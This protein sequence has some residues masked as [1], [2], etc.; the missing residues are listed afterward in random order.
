VAGRRLTRIALAAAL[1][2]GAAEVVISPAFAS[3]PAEDVRPH[4][5]VLS[6]RAEV[7]S[8]AGFSFRT[9]ATLQMGDVVQVVE[10]GKRGGFTRVRLDSGTTGWILTEQVELFGADPTE[11]DIGRM[12]R[13]GRKLRETLLGPPNLATARIGGAL[14]AGALGREGLFL[15]RP[16]VFISPHVAVEGFVGPSVGRETSRGIFGL[17]ANVYLSPHI[18]FTPFLSVGGGA[19]FN[20]G[21][22]DA[23]TDARW[24]YLASPGGGLWIIFKRGVGL[25]FDFRNHVL[26]RADAAQSLQEYS[27]ALAFT[28]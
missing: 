8:G 9:I 24:S 3:P 6:E 4:A 18:P 26:F 19:V 28:F 27:G 5:R 15:V 11:E 20:R 16:S 21:K 7:R 13:F 12:R 10:R 25:R 2:S 17:A 1:A 22:V 23:L 14:S